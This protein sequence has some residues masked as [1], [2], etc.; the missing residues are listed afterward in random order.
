VLA[1]SGLAPLSEALAWA[2]SGLAHTSVVARMEAVELLQKQRDAWLSA[3]DATAKRDIIARRVRP[4]AA[5]MTWSEAAAESDDER[6]LRPRLMAY[7]AEV[8]DEDGELKGRARELAGAWLADHGAV[9]ATLTPAVLDTAARFADADTYARLEKAALGAKDQRERRHLLGALGKVRDAK[10]RSRMLALSLAEDV[11]GYD[12]LELLEAAL[13][14]DSN[15]RAAFD[16]LRENYDALAA[17]LPQSAL[18]S[19][20]VWLMEPLG[21][22]C[23]REERTVFADF[24]KER[25]ARLF[26]GP[27][28]YRQ[29]LERIEICVAARGIK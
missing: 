2:D 17:R 4:L 6:E 5:A 8:A 25:A 10:L 20:I 26:G 27:R 11:N 28:T 1:E 9:S 12:A 16:F 15:R 14:D 21:D 29:A 3:A 22:L 18:A 24:F 23:T 13:A 19:P 7:A